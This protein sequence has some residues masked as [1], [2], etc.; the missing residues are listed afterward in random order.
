MQAATEIQATY[1]KKGEKEERGKIEEKSGGRKEHETERKEKEKAEEGGRNHLQNSPC[2]SCSLAHGELAPSESTA[3][4][5]PAV[6]LPGIYR[7][8][9]P[10][11]GLLVSSAFIRR[12][13]LALDQLLSFL[14]CCLSKLSS[15]CH[16]CVM[17]RSLPSAAELTHRVAPGDIYEVQMLF[18]LISETNLQVLPYL[19]NK[20]HLTYF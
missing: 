11:Q 6:R 14:L 7:F 17:A 12:M 15:R 19:S 13:L 1:K 2:V 16:C 10:F 8:L 5:G 20:C 9:P 3:M 18:M 4:E